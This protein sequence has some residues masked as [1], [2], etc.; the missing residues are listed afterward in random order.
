MICRVPPIAL[1]MLLFVPFLFA[2]GKNKNQDVQDK[3]GYMYEIG[4]RAQ[5]EKIHGAVVV[6]L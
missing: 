1:A 4:V 2:A 6:S 5:L 3:I